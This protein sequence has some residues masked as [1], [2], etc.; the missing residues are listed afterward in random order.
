[1]SAAVRSRA[2]R[3]SGESQLVLE[4]VIAG[5]IITYRIG[6]TQYVAA[7][8]GNVSRLVWGDTGLP[9]VVIFR[10]GGTAPFVLAAAAA[11][12]VRLGDTDADRGRQVFAR[13]CAACHG[14]AGE[15][16]TG[17]ALKS[18]LAALVGNN[19]VPVKVIAPT[20]Y[21]RPS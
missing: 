2:R 5:G 21:C 14:G 19:V 6:R 11:T 15:G 9:S 18:A 8:S 10:H 16:L 4:M 12:P 17:P 3:F 20:L 13:A 7:T 1:M